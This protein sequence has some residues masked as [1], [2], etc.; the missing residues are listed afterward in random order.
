MSKKIGCLLVHGF[1]GD[2]SEVEYLAAYLRLN[3]CSVI[4]TQLKGHTGTRKDMV[5]VRYFQ[6]MQSA[7]KDLQELLNRNEKIFIIGF[8]MGG[9]IGIN[10]SL[11]YNVSGLVCI[12]TPIFCWD[13]KNIGSN[14]LQGIL[15]KDYKN[16]KRYL[17]SIWKY[18]FSSLY[19]FK[20]FVRI[21]KRNLWKIILPTLIV[22]AKDD[23][24]VKSKSA[25]YIY[26][27]INSQNKIIKYF[28]KGGHTILKGPAGKNVS[29]FVLEFILKL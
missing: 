23:D 16:I 4:C 17:Y 18:P 1:G 25:E 28:E 13:L 5:G 24:T 9:L 27:K 14:V 19:N 26:S 22:Q 29:E 8:S 10:L 3:G 6:W 2:V 21:S 7:E 11:K 15:N 12:N 20:L